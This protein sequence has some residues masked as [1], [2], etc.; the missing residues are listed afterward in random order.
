M[1]GGA[2]ASDSRF[3]SLRKADEE[4]YSYIL[5]NRGIVTVRGPRQTGKTSLMMGT[6]AALQVG[7]DNLRPAFVDFQ[8]SGVPDALERM[9]RKALQKDRE[10]R[11]QTGR[12]FALDLE[13]LR[14]KLEAGAGSGTVGSVETAAREFPAAYA[15]A[16]R[17]KGGGANVLN[18]E[19]SVARRMMLVR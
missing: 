2:L 8:D 17:N 5:L 14:R 3:Y 9:V 4:V 7:G 19:S 6:Y 13:S 12:D 16:G 15:H 11:Y 1:P 18:G 10:R